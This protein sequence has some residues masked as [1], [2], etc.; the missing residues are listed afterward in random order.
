MV[1]IGSWRSAV[2][3]GAGKNIPRRLLQERCAVWCSA[4]SGRWSCCLLQACSSCATRGG[5]KITWETTQ[6][7]LPLFRGQCCTGSFWSGLWLWLHS[8]KHILNK[9]ERIELCLLSGYRNCA[10]SVLFKGRGRKIRHCRDV[11]HRQSPNPLAKKFLMKVPGMSWS[12]Y[13]RSQLGTSTSQNASCGCSQKSLMVQEEKKDTGKK[14]KSFLWDLFQGRRQGEMALGG[15]RSCL[16][17]N[18]VFGYSL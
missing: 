6:Q 11:T 7:W 9:D 8:L 3:R 10:G 5:W 4:A 2:C 12:G 13:K 1:K 18:A 14:W 17:P 16:L 15:H